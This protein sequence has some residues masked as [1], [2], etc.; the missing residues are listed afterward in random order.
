MTGV[1]SL[2]AAHFVVGFVAE[3]LGD[4]SYHDMASVVTRAAERSATLRTL[5]RKNIT[6]A[7]ASALAYEDIA[8]ADALMAVTG[9]PPCDVSPTLYRG[10]AATGNI[11]ALG[12]LHQTGVPMPTGRNALVHGALH[13][14]A[15]QLLDAWNGA[16]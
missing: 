2:I 8:Y 6:F 4:N 3:R 5:L 7:L 13:A 10:P 16:A 11:I 12:W 14:D 9:V 15:K 1:T